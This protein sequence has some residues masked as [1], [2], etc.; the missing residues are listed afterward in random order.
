VPDDNDHH[1]LGDADGIAREI[2]FGNL[3]VCI[4]LSPVLLARISFNPT[5]YYRTFEIRKANGGTRIIETPRVFLKVIQWFLLDTVLNRLRVSPAVH[6][7]IHGRSVVTN[8]IRHQKQNYVGNIDI[9][10]YFGSIDNKMVM[11]CLLAAGFTDHECSVVT[12]LCTKDNHLPQGAPT[13]PALSN[14]VLYEFDQEMTTIC[15]NRGVIYTR[16]ADDMTFSGTSRG[17]IV[18]SIRNATEQLRVIFGLKVNNKKTRII[19]KGGQQRVTGVVVNN[20]ATPPRARLRKIRAIFHQAS[21]DPSKFRGKVDELSGYI[22]Y[23]RQFPKLRNGNISENY[24]EIVNKI[25]SL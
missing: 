6:S 16:Y 12:T 23:L 2:D 5:R 7:F 19:S 25:K 11:S 13:S 21:I 18:D 20:L 1:A 8:G 14:S 10:N 24:L 17:D 4:G 9:E 3:A 15:R 22:G